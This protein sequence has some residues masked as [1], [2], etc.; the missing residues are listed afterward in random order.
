MLELRRH[1]GADAAMPLTDF[2]GL[3]D[4]GLPVKAFAALCAGKAVENASDATCG[5]RVTAALDALY[6]AAASGRVERV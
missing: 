4:G 3:Y 2:E 1:D 6:R 5:L